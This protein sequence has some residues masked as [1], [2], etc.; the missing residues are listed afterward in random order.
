MADAAAAGGTPAAGAPQDGTTPAG[1]TPQAG[2]GQPTAAQIAKWKADLGEG[3]QEYDPKHLTELAKRGKKAAQTLSLAERRAQEAQQRHAEAEA[4]E[5]DFKSGDPKRIRAALKRMGVDERSLANNVG[6][7]LLEEMEASKDPTRKALLESQR[8]LREM[9]EGQAKTKAEQEAKALEAETARHQDELATLFT[10]TMARTGLPKESATAVFHRV[11]QLYA[12][13]EGSGT[14]VDPDL[15]AA[16]VRAAVDAEHRAL[17]WNKGADG[18]QTLN[19]E[20]VRALFGSEG[21]DALR[22]HAVEEYRQKRAAG[23]Q[24]TAPTPKP[25]QSEQEPQQKGRGN[26]WKN[27]D[28][29]LKA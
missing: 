10:E 22:R 26:F 17:Y 27:L 16:R 2:K 9:E 28:Q 3:E 23:A 12:A 13:V 5:A 24:P 29:R 6:Q 11:A 4:R 21:F 8:K 20:A 1:T 14:Q 25:Q 18:K 19:I 7:D 15:A